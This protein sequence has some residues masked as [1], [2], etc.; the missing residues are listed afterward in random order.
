MTFTY[1]DVAVVR[2]KTIGFFLIRLKFL[3]KVSIA[4]CLVYKSAV[5]C[6]RQTYN[7]MLYRLYSISSKGIFFS[8]S[9]CHVIGSSWS[10]WCTSEIKCHGNIYSIYNVCSCIPSEKAQILIGLPPASAQNIHVENGIICDNMK[11]L[12]RVWHAWF[13]SQ[14]TV[15]NISAY[16]FF[17]YCSN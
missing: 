16:T 13:Y 17:L 1:C 2:F 6:S 9:N 8:C 11:G 5:S 14:R 7:P 15:G 12:Q 10:A 4:L 3:C